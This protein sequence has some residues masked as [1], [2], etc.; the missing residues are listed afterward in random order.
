VA[1]VAS[2]G[3]RRL[4]SLLSQRIGNLLGLS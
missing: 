4:I 3:L 2:P 1:V